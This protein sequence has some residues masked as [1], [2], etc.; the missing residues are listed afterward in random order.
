MTLTAEHLEAEWLR[1]ALVDATYALEHLAD[2]HPDCLGWINHGE[3]GGPTPE[4]R[5]RA[6]A[7][8]FALNRKWGTPTHLYATPQADTLIAEAREKALEDAARTAQFWRDGNREAIAP[9][10]WTAA[11]I[12]QAITALKVTP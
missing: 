7:A 11:K 3:P 6:N 2:H 5:A 9:V 4:I 12:A 8:R 10:Q 1:K